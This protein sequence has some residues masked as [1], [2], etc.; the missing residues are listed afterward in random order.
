MIQWNLAAIA[1][2]MTRAGIEN[3]K[4]L[5]ERAGISLPTAYAITEAGPLQRI[6]VPTLEA[7]TRTF[8][9]AAPWTLL[10]YVPDPD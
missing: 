4:Q 5:S 3:R 9:L 1:D 2:R 7:L 10:E 6:D 8:G